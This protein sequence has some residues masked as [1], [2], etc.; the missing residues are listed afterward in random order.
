MGAGALQNKLALYFDLYLSDNVAS[1]KIVY[2]FI[3]KC[4]GFHYKATQTPEW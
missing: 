3:D 4:V 1:N 2:D